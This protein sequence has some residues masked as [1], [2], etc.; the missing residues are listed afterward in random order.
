[1]TNAIN[2]N[3]TNFQS[4][5]LDSALP[6]LI[7]FWAPWCGYCTKL[8]PVFDEL[9]VDIGAKVKC[10]KISVDENKALA[11]KYGVLSLP[12]MILLKNGE[13]IEKLMGFMPKAAI[14]D[15]IIPLL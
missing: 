10:V 8:S 14:S 12:T 11:Q 7:D 4:E 1:M 2:V 9:A 3:E 15:K 5:V 6:V 13:Q